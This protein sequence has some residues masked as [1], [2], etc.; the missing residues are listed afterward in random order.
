MEQMNLNK[1]TPYLQTLKIASRTWAR[2]VK[3]RCIHKELF[4]FHPCLYFFFF[5]RPGLSSI[6]RKETT[7]YHR[8]HS[9]R[10]RS[11]LIIVTSTAISNGINLTSQVIS[12]YHPNLALTKK[13]KFTM[14]RNRLRSKDRLKCHISIC[15]SRS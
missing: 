2:P 15:G 3:L 4:Q 5:S 10:K 13:T 7:R 9:H 12:S 8:P 11:G 6:T 14:N 1:F